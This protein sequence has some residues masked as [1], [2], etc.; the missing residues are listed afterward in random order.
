MTADTDTPA[1]TT[2]LLGRWRVRKL[3]SVWL[4]ITPSG[5]A[6]QFCS[7]TGAWCW[8]WTVRDFQR[9]REQAGGDQ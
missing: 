3:G 6:K 2:L 7:W 1:S 9:R 8:V 4:T 5:A